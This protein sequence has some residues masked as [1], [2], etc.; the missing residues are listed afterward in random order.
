MKIFKMLKI[1]DYFTISNIICGFISIIFSINGN[2]LYACIFMLLS[3]LFDFFDGK[4]ARYFKQ[5]NDL[6]KELDS[7]SD[8]VSFG[9]TPAIFG[10]CIMLYGSFF[11]NLNYYLYIIALVFFISCA[12]LRL[13][14]FNILKI[15]GYIGMP[16]TIN[17]IIFPLFYFIFNTTIYFN[18]I[19]IFTFFITALLMISEIKFK[20]I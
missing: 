10:Y 14:R 1:A 2:F 16:V 6:G 11:Y 9:L 20:K 12:L 7:L 8:I 17:G 5:T 3:V 4:I 15:K 19:L 13:A 18:I